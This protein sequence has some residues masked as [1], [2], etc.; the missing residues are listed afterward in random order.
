[1]EKTVTYQLDHSDGPS[2]RL[3]SYIR[4]CLLLRNDGTIC[5]ICEERVVELAIRKEIGELHEVTLYI[6]LFEPREDND[7]GV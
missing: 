5:D 7:A 1:M 6:M 2:D 4:E 3:T